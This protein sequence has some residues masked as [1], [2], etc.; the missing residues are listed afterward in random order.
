MGS[1][2]APVVAVRE[3]ASRN[4]ICANPVHAYPGQGQ[5]RVAVPMQ[6]ADSQGRSGAP[7]QESLELP[8]PSKR[9]QKRDQSCTAK[10]GAAIDCVT[11]G[12]KRSMPS[13]SWPRH[14]VSPLATAAVRA[15]GASTLSRAVASACGDAR[16]K[17]ASRPIISSNS[18]V[19]AIPP[20][21][22][23]PSVEF[24]RRPDGNRRAAPSYHNRYSVVCQQ[25]GF[26]AASRSPG[27]TGASFPSLRRKWSCEIQ[28][29]LRSACHRSRA[30]PPHGA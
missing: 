4:A 2:P 14:A 9:W 24:V 29:T 30:K 19:S 26:L 16:R 11:W 27:R 10:S 18:M 8:R 3:L 5:Q 22:C 6:P 20:S 7:W 25:A 28:I 13:N 15:R 12:G 17:D 23:H 21:S 1:R